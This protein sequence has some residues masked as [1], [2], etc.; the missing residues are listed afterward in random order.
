MHLY[1]KGLGLLC[2]LVFC[3]CFC[4]L[5]K[6]QTVPNERH[7]PHGGSDK[8]TTRNFVSMDHALTCID[9]LYLVLLGRF[10]S[11]FHFIIS[12][13]AP[14]PGVSHKL[15]AAGGKALYV[16]HAHYCKRPTDTRPAF[17][18]PRPHPVA[19]Q[20]RSPGGTQSHRASASPSD[21]LLGGRWV[22]PPRPR[23]A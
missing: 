11:P 23:R 18:A 22:P 21:D 13:L 1:C 19:A 10:L 12:Y 17:G 6:T 14:D 15:I 8:S 4:S 3:F 20:Q 2:E 16:A 5:L 7:T 9:V